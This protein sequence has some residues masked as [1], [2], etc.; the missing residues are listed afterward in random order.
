MNLKKNFMYAPLAIVAVGGMA[1][2]F[3]SCGKSSKTAETAPAEEAFVV[4]SVSYADS[5]RVGGCI[6]TCSLTADYPVSGNELLVKNVRNW[7]AKHMAYSTDIFPDSEPPKVFSGIADG[8]VFLDSV[9]TCL[10][11][12]AKVD[13]DEYV[14]ENFSTSYEYI[15][16][17]S[18]AYRTD[19]YVTYF[20]NNYIY[21]G[22]A[23]GSTI[24]DDAVFSLKTGEEFGWNM[25][26]PDSLP[27]IK[28]II[29]K[30]L[31]TEFFK[32]K[33]AQE[34]REALLIDPDTL[35][36]P[37]TAPYFL[38]DGV[39]FV[40]Q[41]YEIAPYASGMPGCIV[42]YSVVM[43]MFTPAVKEFFPAGR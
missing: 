14:K 27:A 16:S 11:S 12:Q 6:V 20:S 41:Q 32:V 23:H 10:L 42:P 30:D 36:L 31:M 17:A 40:Y 25:F 19:T 43:D 24:V 39:H 33:D 9:G 2:S 5:L 3:L 7:I 13:F 37:S 15:F 22:G 4:D 38:A 21:T 35:P 18:E 34:F 28:K 29:K 26:I 8:K 1:L